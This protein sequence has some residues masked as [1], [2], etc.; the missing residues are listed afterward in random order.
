MP[1][2][3]LYTL[4]IISSCSLCLCP[5]SKQPLIYSLPPKICLF[6][7]FSGC[8]SYNMWSFANDSSLDLLRFIHVK[9]RIS[10]SFLKNSIIILKN[11]DKKKHSPFPMIF[12]SLC[13]CTFPSGI[14]F[15]LPE[16]LGLTFLTV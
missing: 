15:L 4:V 9:A 11:L 2:K 7:L 5:S 10:A 12:I 6:W 16:G 8:F 14:I 3:N 13:R 1:K